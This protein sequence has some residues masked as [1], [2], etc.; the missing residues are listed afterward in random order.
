MHGAFQQGHRGDE[1]SKLRLFE[2]NSNA[3]IF[4]YRS[5]GGSVTVMR[6]MTGQWVLREREKMLDCDTYRVDLAERN[7]LELMYSDGKNGWTTE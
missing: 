7:D 3:E 4:G 5:A 1:M 6:G 2:V